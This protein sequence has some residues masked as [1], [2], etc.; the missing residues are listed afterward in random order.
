MH[1]WQRRRGADDPTPEF[2]LRPESASTVARRTGA[3]R[4]P[5]RFLS[6]DH[7]SA[8]A[9]AAYV[10]GQLPASGQMRAGHHLERC[11]MCREEV[12][13]QRQARQALRGSGPIQMPEELR[14]R[15]H[16]LADLGPQAPTPDRPATL[17]CDGRPTWIRRWWIRRF[18]R[19]TD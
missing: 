19:R 7:L 5:A 14:D 2:R 8:E 4:P 3:P 16:R 18:G 15:L 12:D 13:Q 17:R 1:W 11:R 6:T 10:D 9:V